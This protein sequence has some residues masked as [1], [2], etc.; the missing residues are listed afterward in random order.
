MNRHIL[1]A[2]LGFAISCSLLVSP[3]ASAQT[4]AKDC[5]AQAVDKNGKPLTGAAKSTFMKKCE[6]AATSSSSAG[7]AKADC[8][9]KAVSKKTGK[10]LY[11]AAKNAFMKKCQAD[12]K[13]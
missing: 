9:A 5:A 13:K 8:E 2:L 11:G 10:P 12:A 3:I 4:P 1:A 7:G 6:G